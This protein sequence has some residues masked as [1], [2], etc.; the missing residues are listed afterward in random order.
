MESGLKKDFWDHFIVGTLAG[1][2]LGAILVF[3][4]AYAAVGPEL[5]AARFEVSRI[6]YEATRRGYG[7]VVVK[8]PDSFWHRQVVFQWEDSP[9]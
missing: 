2:I 9:K 8:F 4:L 3:F 7:H 5:F 6:Q 1:I